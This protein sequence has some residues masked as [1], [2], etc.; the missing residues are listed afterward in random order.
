M[1][2]LR[3]LF[4]RRSRLARGLARLVP[5][6]F[7]AEC[8]VLRGR[9]LFGGRGNRDLGFAG[10]EL[11]HRYTPVSTALPG[12]PVATSHPPSAAGV[13]QLSPGL[14]IILHPPP[15]TLSREKSGV[16]AGVQRGEPKKNRTR[17]T[18]IARMP[19]DK[20]L[21]THLL[22]RVNPFHSRHPRSMAGLRLFC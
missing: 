13:E 14:H 4:S 1:T 9:G 3:I 21:Q 17:M 5:S 18:R 8:L 16:R 19:A 12:T 20:R 22:L 11:R 2:Q 10:R 15:P 6:P 7:S